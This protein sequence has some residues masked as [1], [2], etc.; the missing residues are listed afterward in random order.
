MNRRW[1]RFLAVVTALALLGAPALAEAWN[2]GEPDAGE[3]EWTIMAFVNG[4]NNLEAAALADLLEMEKGLPEGGTVEVIALLDRSDKYTKDLGDWSGARV[5]HVKRSADE[6]TLAS[7]QLA[8][9]GPLDMSGANTLV[10]FVKAATAKYPAKKTALVMWN[11]G[12]GWGGMS[13][14]EG[15][16]K[17]RDEKNPQMSM[18]GK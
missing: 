14:D 4:D 15:A 11:H 1:A 7:E 6:K 9:L 12:G 13:S 5:F 3:R 10:R 18:A 16:K 17:D 2:F 8:D